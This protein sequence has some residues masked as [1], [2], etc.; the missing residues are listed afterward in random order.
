VR[1]MCIM[2]HASPITLHPP[3]GDYRLSSCRTVLDIMERRIPF[4][5]HGGLSFV[6]VR[7]VASAFIAAMQSAPRTCQHGSIQDRI[8]LKGRR[9]PHVL[10]SLSAHPVSFIPGLCFHSCHA[11][12]SS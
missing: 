4:V 3:P 2:C 11:V 9:S 12:R 5:P 7:D 1:H 8:T 6:D 10:H